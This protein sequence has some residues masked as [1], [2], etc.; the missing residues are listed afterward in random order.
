MYSVCVCVCVC[1]RGGVVDVGYTVSG[2]KLYL[3]SS[4]TTETGPVCCPCGRHLECHPNPHQ[5]DHSSPPVRL[6]SEQSL[7]AGMPRPY[8][9][10]FP[11]KVTQ[12][13][14]VAL[15]LLVSSMYCS[16]F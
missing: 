4:V 10:L 13:K 3:E 8:V 16:E 1:E 11:R 5:N 6:Q 2:L 7:Q 12:S 15:L 14:Q 9:Q